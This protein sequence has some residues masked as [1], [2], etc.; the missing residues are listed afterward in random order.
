MP[1]NALIAPAQNRT[2][3]RL[4]Q[5]IPLAAAPSI[6]GI[7]EV[8]NVFNR[9]NWSIGT[10]GKQRAQYLQHMSAQNRTAQFGFRLTF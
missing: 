5:R 10:R 4:Q 7:A 2:D 6:D 1:R 3:L 9:P 8:F